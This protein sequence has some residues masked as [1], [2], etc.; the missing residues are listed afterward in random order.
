MTEADGIDA[1]DEV[2]D[3]CQEG[4]DD[5]EM[6]E[7]GILFLDSV[8]NKVVNLQSRIKKFGDVT[9]GQER[10]IKNWRAG[11]QRWVR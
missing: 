2:Y 6:S 11:V 7:D 4:L 1:C 5:P 10:A 3:A 9:P 8:Q